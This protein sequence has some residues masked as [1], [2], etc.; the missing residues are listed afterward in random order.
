VGAGDVTE[1][2]AIS[3][4]IPVHDAAATLPAQ[5]DA[6]LGQTGVPP[7]EVVVANDRSRDGTR[8][9]VEAYVARDPRVRLVD[10]PGPPGPS[11]TR[12]VAVRSARARVVACC[13]ADDVVADGWLVA[14]ARALDRHAFVGGVLEV[15]SLNDPLVVAARG[16]SIPGRLGELHGLRFAH[17]CN[18]GIER[19]RFL[20]VGGFD[21]RLQAGEEIDLAI[22]LAQRGVH[23]REEPCA[24]VHYRYRSEPAA[25]RR[26]AFAY[27]EVHPYL[28]RELRAAG[29]A[30]PK[31]FA[32]LRQ[33]AWLAKSA[34]RRDTDPA[35]ELRREWVLASKRGQLAGCW[36][37]RTVYV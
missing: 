35:M 2:P 24:I 28:A 12:N 27:G 37:H 23:V 5:L 32:G 26:Q 34:L 16:T 13:D 8:A 11:A 10:S 36:H 31:R 33:W 18:L 17:G 4:A 20:D 30:H 14:M 15:A 6:V 21:Q 7:F 22:R 19:A 1:T 9:I 25:L 29:L 3:V